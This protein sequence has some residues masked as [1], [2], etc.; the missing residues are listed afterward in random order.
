MEDKATAPKTMQ[1][2]FLPQPLS[3]EHY[4]LPAHMWGELEVGSPVI[5]Q[6]GSEL[7]AGGHVDMV[8]DDGSIF[9]VWLNSGLGRI[10]VYADESTRVWLSTSSNRQ[11]E[12]S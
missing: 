3:E 5:V 12:Q 7:T 11:S 2:P 10:A 4:E 1:H 8:T 6:R 9:W